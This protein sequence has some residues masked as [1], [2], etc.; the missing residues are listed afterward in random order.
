MKE[1]EKGI[2]TDLFRFQRSKKQ[3]NDS[4]EHPAR[5]RHSETSAF[6]EQHRA[7]AKHGQVN[8]RF[9]FA[10]FSL[11]PKGHKVQQRNEGKCLNL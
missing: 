2:P 4:A 11:H 7:S 1:Q 6:F 3:K 8:G 5:V 10:S 9:S